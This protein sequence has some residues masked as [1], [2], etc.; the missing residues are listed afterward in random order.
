MRDRC[1]QNSSLLVLLFFV[2]DIGERS[3]TD[4]PVKGSWRDSGGGA[5]E[6]ATEPGVS[7]AAAGKVSMLCNANAEVD[8]VA[9]V[10]ADRS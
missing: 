9:S 5:V 10:R 2:G 4:M 1:A 6:V 3:P 7:D 8:G